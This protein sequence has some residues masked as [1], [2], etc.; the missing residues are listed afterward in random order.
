MPIPPPSRRTF[1]RT[2]VEQFFRK[3][4]T[5]IADLRC[6]LTRVDLLP[7]LP[8]GAWLIEYTTILEGKPWSLRYRTLVLLQLADA[9]GHPYLNLPER[10][11]LPEGW[12]T[13]A[14]EDMAIAA[15]KQQAL[16]ALEESV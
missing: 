2:E 5:T 12:S 4:F 10:C 13:P 15:H 9:F 11:P 1:T 3:H 6:E 7:Q 8:S 14:E 16:A